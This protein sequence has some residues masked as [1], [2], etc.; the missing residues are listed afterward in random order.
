MCVESKEEVVTWNKNFCVHT[1]VFVVAMHFY[2]TS[3][4]VGS[5]LCDIIMTWQ[6][7]LQVWRM[8]MALCSHSHTQCHGLKNNQLYD[9][10]PRVNLWDEHAG[11]FQAGEFV[12]AMN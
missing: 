1:C 2:S 3:I 5:T 10:C 8:E 6:A 4:L 9:G 12:R 7:T 11:F